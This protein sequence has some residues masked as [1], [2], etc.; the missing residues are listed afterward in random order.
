MRMLTKIDRLLLATPDAAASDMTER[1]HDL[2]DA[3]AEALLLEKL[4]TL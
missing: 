2:T 4:G 1:I 3:E